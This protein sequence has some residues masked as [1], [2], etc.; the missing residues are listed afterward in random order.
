MKHLHHEHRLVLRNPKTMGERLYA[1]VWGPFVVVGLMVLFVVIHP[2]QV[3]AVNVTIPLLLLACL[4]TLTRI[5]IAYALAVVVA[6]P[7]ALLVEK[8][9]AVE[10][11]L[12]PVFDVFESIPNLAVLPL[13]VVVFMQFNFLSGATIVILFL[14]MV[15]SI[16]FALVSGL[17]IIPRDAYFA[18]R[19][20]GLSGLSLLRRLILP[21]VFPQFVTGSILAV[22]SA[23]NIIIV[24]EVVHSYMPGATSAQDIFGIG[25]ILVATSV[26]GATLQYILAFAVMVAV[27]ALFNFFVWQKLLNYSQR[28]RFE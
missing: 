28:F 5:A 3:N 16:V 21:A 14:N 25:S 11:V 15:W 1:L 8:S 2:P 23:W 10:S 13:L 24:A 4:Y 7:L 9:R 27:I 18:A 19:V 17:K 20:F 22:A 12:L 26:Q 6:V